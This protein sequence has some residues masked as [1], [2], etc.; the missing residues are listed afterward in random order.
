MDRPYLNYDVLHSIMCFADRPTLSCLMQTSRELYR[1]AAKHI[2]DERVS[3]ND[4]DDINALFPFLTA[5]PVHR[6]PL[7]RRLAIRGH[8]GSISDHAASL[9]NKLVLSLVPVARLTNLAIWNAEELLGAHPYLGSALAS[10]TSVRH[11]NLSDS[12]K[13]CARML[14]A[15][16]SPLV[17]ANLAFRC[18][19][20]ERPIS[21]IPNDPIPLLR[22]SAQSLRYL[23]TKSS[24]SVLGVPSAYPG[25]TDL[26]ISYTDMPDVTQYVQAFPHLRYL[27]VYECEEDTR[28]SARLMA[29]RRHNQA[30]QREL[31]SWPELERYEGSIT[32]L[33]YLAL[34]CP[35]A[36]VVLNDRENPGLT[37]RCL[38]KF[39]TMLVQNT[40]S[41]RSPEPAGFWTPHS[42]LCSPGHP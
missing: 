28:D 42:R 31:L 6:L 35:I 19:V 16:Q 1:P 20:D 29:Q 9:A 39:W 2:L 34:A 10:L 14:S 30:M 21:D 37:R 5:D 18:D 27:K 38:L 40:W 3:F 36:F 24:G 8:Y 17:S 4:G 23:E 12:G 7:I 22:H 11:L 26:V 15:F 33:Y 25:V 41:S 13:L 32:S